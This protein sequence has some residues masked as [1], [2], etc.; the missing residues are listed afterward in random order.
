MVEE[1][2]IT[3]EEAI[4]R[5]DPKSIDQLL[6]KTFSKDGLKEAKEIGEGLAASPGAASG[7]VYFDCK[8]I[9]ENGGGILVRV[10][11][12]PEDIEGM[13]I[14]EGILTVRGGMTSHAAVV[15]RGM[16]K[17]CVCGCSELTIN[18][19]KKELESRG[20]I[21]K[22]GEYISLD[23]SS[24]KVYFRPKFLRVKSNFSAAFEKFISWVDSKQELL[25]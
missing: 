17:C 25:E 23:G 2:L 1:G 8:S 18:E 21:I 10:E 9:K 11:T 20:V 4:L 22:E 16:G 7:K 14:A 6:H 13:N 19:E 12:S 5:I 3:K 15:A 24:G